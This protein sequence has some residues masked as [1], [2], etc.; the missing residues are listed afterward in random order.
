MLIPCTRFQASFADPLIKLELNT[1]TT[2]MWDEHG[3]TFVLKVENLTA[4]GLTAP[5]T[6]SGCRLEIPLIS[7]TTLIS[8]LEEFA[9]LH[10]LPMAAASSTPTLEE[11]ALLAACHLPG[12]NLFIFAEEPIL[13][14]TRRGNTVELAVTGVF[15]ARRVPCQATDLVIHLSKAAMAGLVAYVLSQARTRLHRG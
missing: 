4:A 1:P 8:A 7:D 14:A 6:A 13:T 9:G 12:Q 10:Q 5:P 2:L 3:G 15:K 11:P